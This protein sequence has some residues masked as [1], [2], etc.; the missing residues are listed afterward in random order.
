M[1]DFI[2]IIIESDYSTAFGYYGANL[3]DP[4]PRQNP[5][6]IEKKGFFNYSYKSGN[7]LHVC[8]YAPL[9]SIITGIIRIVLATIQLCNGH[10]F[11]DSPLNQTGKA[12]LYSEI[13]RGVCE[14]MQFTLVLLLIDLIFTVGRLLSRP[15]NNG[16]LPN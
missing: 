8:G 14:V 9:L 1:A 3:S 16:Y 11:D 2:K 7:A 13:G 4:M 5:D 12:N 6:R 15:E 10:D